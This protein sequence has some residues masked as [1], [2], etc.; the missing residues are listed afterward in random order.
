MKVFASLLVLAFVAVADSALNTSAAEAKLKEGIAK[1]NKAIEDAKQQ[2]EYLNH[3]INMKVFASLLVLAFVA[4]AAS[5]LDT[6]AAEAKLKEGVAKVNQAIEDAKQ[7]IAEIKK[8]LEAAAGPLQKKILEKIAAALGK[9]IEWLQQAKDK[10]EAKAPAS[11]AAVNPDSSLVKLAEGIAKIGK[12][13][14]ELKAKLA[15]V[16]DK[17]KNAAGPLQKNVLAKVQEGLNK[18]LQKLT[19]LKEKLQAKL[20]KA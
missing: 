3:H 17:I 5:A 6:S 14:D 1:V 16:A 10:L 13:I 11:R 4:V 20:P 9:Q 12:G 18:Q 2:L 8:K 19:E 7:Q 15:K